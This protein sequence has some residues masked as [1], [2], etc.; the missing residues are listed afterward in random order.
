MTSSSF[1]FH[2]SEE[3]GSVLEF[4]VAVRSAALNALAPIH[5]DA[6]ALSERGQALCSK[7]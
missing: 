4:C 1:C 3:A 7:R 2:S 6:R 5:P